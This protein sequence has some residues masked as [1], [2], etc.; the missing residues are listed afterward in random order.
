MAQRTLLYMRLF[1]GRQ[2]FVAGAA[3]AFLILNFMLGSLGFFAVYDFDV[4]L[5]ATDPGALPRGGAAVA[6]LLRWAGAIDMLG[7]LAL[8]PV[9][10][11]LHA[12]LKL[13][14]GERTERLVLVDLLAS[15]GLGFVLVGAIGAVL[16]ASEGAGLLKLVGT[17]PASSES[18]RIAFRALGNA[19]YVGLWGT[20]ELLL[21]GI[22][23]IGVAW[24]AR[25]EGRAF[26]WLG[27]VAG[28]G[29][30]GYA[31][32]TGLSGQTPVALA[33]LYD[34]VILAGL[35]LLSVWL[36]WLAVRLWRG[37]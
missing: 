12:R 36:L 22:W 17:D 8:A 4:R 32:R 13:A 28:L 20:L 11:S 18:A 16:M 33:G 26:A 23:L 10:F 30:I 35:G 9:V 25:A 15:S 14:A 7:Y 37:R 27:V 5:L 29:A 21:L 19:V 6:D 2:R 1:G 3:L 31:T 34:F 24:L